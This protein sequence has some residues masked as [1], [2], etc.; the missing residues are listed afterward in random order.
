MEFIY[1]VLWCVLFRRTIRLLSCGVQPSSSVVK[2]PLISQLVPPLR[3]HLQ[4]LTLSLGGWF[5]FA[6]ISLV[7]KICCIMSWDVPLHCDGS[8]SCSRGALSIS[9]C[10][11][12]VVGTL[13][14]NAVANSGEHW[15]LYSQIHASTAGWLMGARYVGHMAVLLAF[16]WWG[17]A[18][19]SW[20]SCVYVNSW[21]W[22]Q[23]LIKDIV[24]TG[25][26]PV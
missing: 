14:R 9:R 26:K 13:G 20:T 24:V 10:H 2:F 22:H 3:S 23:L 19:Q 15:F 25:D 16:Q 4:W 21:S 11:G 18:L 5:H 7:I 17:L 1:C 8:E 6:Q 12:N